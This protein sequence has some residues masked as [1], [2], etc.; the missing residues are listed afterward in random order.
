METRNFMGLIKSV[1]VRESGMHILSIKT[2]DGENV[3]VFASAQSSSITSTSTDEDGN[4]SEVT[5]EK[6]V[7]GH[8]YDFS[9]RVNHAGDAV[10]D[11]E[12]N[13]VLT[14]EGTQRYFK[15][16][17]LSLLGASEIPFQLFKDMVMM[18]K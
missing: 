8:T 14:D 15:D 16:D 13:A 12:G 10:I 9:V 11:R 5:S 6:F 3:A 7:S 18:F 2:E 4:E 17:S 1:K